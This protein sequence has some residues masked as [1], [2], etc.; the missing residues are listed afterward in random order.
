M[1][2]SKG[3]WNFEG[4]QSMK[5]T[6]NNFLYYFLCI[7]LCSTIKVRLKLKYS[8]LGIF[9]S[10]YLLSDIFFRNITVVRSAQN[11]QRIDY[12]TQSKRRGKISLYTWVQTNQ[13]IYSNEIINAAAA[14]RTTQTKHLQSWY[15]DTYKNTELFGKFYEFSIFC[16]QFSIFQRVTERNLKLSG[17]QIVKSLTH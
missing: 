16:F 12:V 5:N 3:E 11:S 6:E 14:T 8:G 13:R 7:S 17:F 9:L 2:A 10:L 4:T 15:W 1:I